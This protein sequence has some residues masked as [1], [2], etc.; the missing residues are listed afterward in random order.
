MDTMA[1]NCTDTSLLNVF[2]ALKL[3]SFSLLL[4]PPFISDLKQEEAV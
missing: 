4:S 2:S 1:G 3:S